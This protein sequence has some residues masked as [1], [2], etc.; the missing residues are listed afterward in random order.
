[1][2][3]DDDQLAGAI[4]ETMAVYMDLGDHYARRP[5]DREGISKRFGDLLRVLMDNFSHEAHHV[6]SEDICEIFRHNKQRR[7]AFEDPLD[8]DKTV[9]VFNVTHKDLFTWYPACVPVLI[10]NDIVSMRR[11]YLPIEFNGFRGMWQ[12]FILLYGPKLPK[13]GEWETP[14]K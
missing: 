4:N 12:Q 1:M 2:F 5:N 9:N 6:S 8:A 10:V 14:I 3:M 7:D 11:P 13:M